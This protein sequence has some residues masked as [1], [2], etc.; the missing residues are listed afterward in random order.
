MGGGV[1]DFNDLSSLNSDNNNNLILSNNSSESSVKTV[2]IN[3]VEVN[4]DQLVYKSGG[5]EVESKY[6]SIKI[7]VDRLAFRSS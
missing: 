5:G 6:I 2:D 1:G 3:S 7:K 4:G